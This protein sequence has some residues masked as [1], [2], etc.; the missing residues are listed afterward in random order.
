MASDITLILHSVIVLLVEQ[1]ESTDIDL[2]TS[3][4]LMHP[5]VHSAQDVTVKI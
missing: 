4:H 5:T 2:K 3:G 1:I